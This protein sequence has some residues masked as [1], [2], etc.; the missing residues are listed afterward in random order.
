MEAR[1]D[2]NPICVALD[3][4]EPR[5]VE[6]LALAVEAHVAL[7]KVGLTA[8]AAGGPPL[9]KTLR[10][11]RPVFLD[12]KFHDIP[13]QVAGATAAVS[14]LGVDY[15]TVHGLGG[16][17]MVAAAVDAA[18]GR[19]RILAVT[20][21]T[22]LDSGD[23]QQ[24]GIAR[25]PDDAVARLA[26]VAL[27]AGAD[28]LVCSPLEVAGLR[29]RFGGRRDGGP[30]LAVP[31]IRAEASGDDQ[32]R[33]MRVRAALDAG[34]DLLVVGRPITAAADPARAAAALLE[35]AGRT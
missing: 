15:V 23:L 1:L 30:L 8:F 20:V 7:F 19:T 2:T 4:P 17:D 10:E 34:A 5:E 16:R 6:R 26:E 3:S 18:A 33:T 9:V 21:L 22:S 24:L 31:G 14:S 27:G 29:R 25:G 32:K 35:E 12:L 13:A 28:G 11:R